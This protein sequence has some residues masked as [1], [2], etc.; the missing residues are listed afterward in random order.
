MNKITSYNKSYTIHIHRELENDKRV[1]FDYGNS[2]YGLIMRDSAIAEVSK[3]AAKAAFDANG[4][5]YGAGYIPAGIESGAE[6]IHYV[7]D[8]W[9]S[10]N[11]SKYTNYDKDDDAVFVYNGVNSVKLPGIKELKDSLGNV[12][13]DYTNIN[14]SLEVKTL[15]PGVPPADLYTYFS[16]FGTKTLSGQC[17]SD[18]SVVIND[19]TGL[20][21][22]P[23]VYMAKYEYKDFDGSL[24]S[25]TRPV[26]ILAA[27][28]D[29]NIDGVNDS[30]DAQ[31]IKSRYIY[32]LPYESMSNYEI[33]GSIY[34]YR[35]CDANIDGDVNNADARKTAGAALPQ[36]FY[37]D[38][39]E[40]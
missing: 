24:T 11:I 20:R 38:L 5:K 17:V 16:S 33:G 23:D 36:K 3:E 29:V 30:A 12:I 27:N 26:I 1:N 8:A 13:D 28:G 31:A 21:I 40:E 32:Q 9:K 35:V 14:V 25:V 4:N 2:P 39:P 6:N 15:N 37:T 10:S 22:R 7:E 19:M 34:K 18:G